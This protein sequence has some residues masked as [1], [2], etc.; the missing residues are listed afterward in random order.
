MAAFLVAFA[1]LGAQRHRAQSVLGVHKSQTILG[2]HKSTTTAWTNVGGTANTAWMALLGNI[3]N[4][5]N[6]PWLTHEGKEWCDPSND[7]NSSQIETHSDTY[8]PTSSDSA[9][10]QWG[11]SSTAQGLYVWS[12]GTHAMCLQYADTLKAV[13]GLGYLVLCPAMQPGAF[14]IGEWVMKPVSSVLWAYQTYPNLVGKKLAIGGHSGGGPVAMAA[15]AYLAN[16]HNIQPDTY[17]LQ[18]PGAVTDL[19]VPGCAANGGSSSDVSYCNMYFPDNAW[20]VLTGKTL[21]TCGTFCEV[22]GANYSAYYDFCKDGSEGTP[23]MANPSD[24]MTSTL[25]TD[26]EKTFIAANPNG[27]VLY[28]HCG[29]HVFQTTGETGLQD[30]GMPVVVPWLQGVLDGDMDT[31][32]STIAMYNGTDSNCGIILDVNGGDAMMNLV[33]MMEETTYGDQYGMTS[34]GE[35]F[36]V[37]DNQVVKIT[38]PSTLRGK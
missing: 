4:W 23:W 33:N 9:L 36:N 12:V 3:S 14:T 32:A 26:M 20:S 31:A 2:V 15:G 25:C 5:E 7:C 27:G 13:A 1:S 30:E 18:H 38:P 29:E 37:T 19:N 6:H 35:W 16:N 34:Y 24:C 28:S 8:I 22:A 21:V 11:D 17:V 10:F